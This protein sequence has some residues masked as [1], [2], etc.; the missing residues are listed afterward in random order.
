MN[1]LEENSQV[2]SESLLP[3]NVSPEEDKKT[4]PYKK[5]ME[6]GDAS[7]EKDAATD[8]NFHRYFENGEI[9]NDMDETR[10][11]FGY[12]ER[13]H[14]T[15]IDDERSIQM[16]WEN[17]INEMVKD[18]RKE[19]EKQHEKEW[20]PEETTAKK[21]KI[22]N[23]VTPEDIF[24]KEK[25]SFLKSVV[26]A[27]GM[28]M[29]I[30]SNEHKKMH[31]QDVDERIPRE[32][33]LSST[34]IDINKIIEEDIRKKMGKKGLQTPAEEGIQK[35][36]ENNGTPAEK[37]IR[38]K[39]GNNGAPAE[40][41][42]R[43]KIGN[44]GTP[45][46]KDTRKNTEEKKNVRKPIVWEEKKNFRKPIV[47]EENNLQKRIKSHPTVVG[48]VA[49]THPAN[50]F[51]GVKSFTLS[52]FQDCVIKERCTP[53]WIT[54]LSCL[55]KKMKITDLYVQGNR[56]SAYLSKHLNVRVYELPK[57]DPTLKCF[58]CFR[59][60]CSIFKVQHFFRSYFAYNIPI[61]CYASP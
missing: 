57:R 54:Q 5:A 15:V 19:H 38:K 34:N 32:E 43:K 33:F 20:I 8:L 36:I 41:N 46:E 55:V 10:K 14:S 59:K 28:N 24:E 29:D 25:T 3:F 4:E 9:C 6:I 22:S 60:S 12:K 48:I 44:N 39:I 30:N 40:K 53:F 49:F 37:D 23:L 58:K 21:I 52:T 1:S 27:K 18:S 47:W 61:K 56:Q 17:K 16:I 26:V 45:A 7:T 35:K 13:F 2:E 42:I 11:S 31:Y 50:P 51:E